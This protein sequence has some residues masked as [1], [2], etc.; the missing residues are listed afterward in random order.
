MSADLPAEILALP[1]RLPKS[2]ETRMVNADKCRELVRLAMKDDEKRGLRRAVTKGCY[3]GNPPMSRTP[4][5][6]GWTCNLN[7]GEME[8]LMD[9]ARIPY[10]ALFSGVQNLVV[11]KNGYQ[12][13]TSENE[14]WNK[15]IAEKWTELIERWKS[16]R[17]HMRASEFEMLFEGWGPL[18]FDDAVDWRF[19]SVPARC[20]KVPQGAYSCVDERLP[21]VV[22]LRDWRVH[23]LWEKI[24]DPAAATA[25]GWNVKAVENAITRACNSKASTQN[26]WE[27]WQQRLKNADLATSY[28]ESDVIRCGTVLVK[29][30]GRA[31]KKGKISEFIVTVDDVGQSDPKKKTEGGDYLYAQPNLYDRYEQA[32]IVSF[33]N[34][35]DGTWHSVRGLALKSFKHIE[36][37]NRLKCRAVDGAFLAAGP[38]VQPGTNQ[39]KDRAQMTVLGP[40]TTLAPGATFVQHRLAADTAGILAVDRVLSNHL[41]Q[42][43]GHYNQ[44]SISRDDGRGEQ[45][46]ATAVELQAGKETALS[47]A[48]IDSRYDDLDTTWQEMFARAVKGPDEESRRFIRE[49]LEAGVP[50]EALDQMVT[51]KANRLSGY[52]S[53][54]MRKRNLTQIFSVV[55]MLPEDGK[56]ALVDELIAVYGGPDKVDVFNP[57]LQAPDLDTA[58]IVLENAAMQQGETPVV[59]SGMNHVNHLQGHLQ[60]AA[61]KM[62]PLHDEMDAGGSIEPDELQEAY[63]YVQVLG[64][65]CEQHLQPLAG[66]PSRKDLFKLFST[67]LKNLV[68]FHGKLRGAILDAQR[69]AQQQAMEED[70]ATALG[71]KD[72]AELQSMQADIARSDAVAA[73]DVRRKD[74]KVQEDQKR[75]TWQAGAN[76]RLKAATTV[77]DLR[78]KKTVA[79]GGAKPVGNG[80]R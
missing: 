32:L 10:Y 72:Q 6:Y 69:Q 39:D 17:W 14:Q 56:R 23:E 1:T 45:P 18:R 67:Q 49:C 22:V 77:A 38:I 34:T 27:Y 24:S 15:T 51:V 60:D 78:I 70:Q 58:L 7:F 2:A 57:K 42:N 35:G 8:G 44:R 40:I 59:I 68:A 66:D 50:Q 54:E 37:S 11:F 4:P 53:P 80:N 16:F 9:T 75:K 21:W 63:E 31:G 28:T 46:T 13:G 73:A 30:C 26:D 29:E 25:R 64:A 47:Q 20:I 65:H 61:Q 19:T 52:P 79:A 5:G 62:Q 76:H 71:V 43:V 33:Q 48:Q 12:R 3:D 74:F 36:V 55:G 41:A